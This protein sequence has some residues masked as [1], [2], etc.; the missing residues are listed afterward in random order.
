MRSLRKHLRRDLFAVVEGGKN[1][2][3]RT[4]RVEVTKFINQPTGRMFFARPEKN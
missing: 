1:Y 3:D 4:I 2:M